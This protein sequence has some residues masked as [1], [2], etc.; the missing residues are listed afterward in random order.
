[1]IA[2]ALCLLGFAALVVGSWL[3]Y[4]PAAFLVAGVLLLA[5]GVLYVRGSRV[6]V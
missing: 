1:L 3:V 4:E 2:I 5:A 6:V